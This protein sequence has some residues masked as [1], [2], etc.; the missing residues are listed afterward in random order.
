MQLAGLFFVNICRRSSSSLPQDRPVP[1]LVQQ[2]VTQTNDIFY[3]IVMLWLIEEKERKGERER[4]RPKAKLMAK[5]N[6]GHENK[7]KIN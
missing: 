4:S 1:S 5:L 2:E 6:L 7:K 3:G